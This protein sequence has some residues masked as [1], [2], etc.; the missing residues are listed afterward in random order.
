M[1]FLLVIALCLLFENAYGLSFVTITTQRPVDKLF[2]KA[3]NYV[4][5]V[6]DNRI[7]LST[8][9]VKALQEGDTAYYDK[10]ANCFILVTKYKYPVFYIKN[11]ANGQGDTVKPA[12]DFIGQPD[13]SFYVAGKKLKNFD[14]LKHSDKIDCMVEEA[15]DNIMLEQCPNST[16]VYFPIVNMYIRLSEKDS[17]LSEKDFCLCDKDLFIPRVKSDHYCIPLAQ[18]KL[19]CMNKEETQLTWYVDKWAK[20]SDAS[21]KNFINLRLVISGPAYVS[22]DNYNTSGVRFHYS[23]RMDIVL[24]LEKDEKLVKWSNEKF[25]PND[26]GGFGDWI[27]L[28]EKKREKKKD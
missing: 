9:K 18:L 21:E 3:K 16:F 15:N 14:T 11:L 10:T 4:K 20:S 5:V 13:F 19:S 28:E 2:C 8:C 12:T 23:F 22:L 6:S 1:R 26:D 17:A 7:V 27:L 25:N 24:A